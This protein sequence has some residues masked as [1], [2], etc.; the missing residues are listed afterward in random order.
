MSKAKK[1]SKKKKIIVITLS[2][3]FALIVAVV[4]AGLVALDWYCTVPDYRQIKTSERVQLIAHRGYS[5]AA[6]ENTAPAFEE[7]AKAMYWGAECDVYMTKDGVW[8]ITHD[9]STYRV[10]GKHKMIESLTYDELLQMTVNH[11]ANIENYPG[12]KFLTLDE[13]MK[14]CSDNAMVPVIELKGKNNTEHYDKLVEIVNKYDSAEPVYISFHYENLQK[15]RELTD[16]KVYYLVK[17]IT[18][19]DIAMAK[20]LDNCGINFNANNE[21]NFESGA[22]DKC[23]NEGLDMAAWTVDTQE[24]LDKLLENGVTTVTTNCISYEQ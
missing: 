23:H 19:E 11:G 10:T 4:A 21:K 20:A 16:A 3:L 15:I 6:P 1:W 13:Y 8:V 14:I 7:A 2:V 5:S 9:V 22:I 12:L 17:E 24:V 18:D